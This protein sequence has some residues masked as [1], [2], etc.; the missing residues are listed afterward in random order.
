M[1]LTLLGRRLR[2]LATTFAAGALVLT[3]VAAVLS[4]RDA[5]QPDLAEGAVLATGVLGAIGALLALRWWSN[6]GERRRSAAQIQVGFIARIAVAETGLFVGFIGVVITGALVAAIVGLAL[7][8]L[9][10][11]ALVLGLNRI[12]AQGASDSPIV[13]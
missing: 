9:A 3:L 4:T 13:N 8:L 2:L 11:L 10:L 1:D 12:E 5:A 7:F 6:A